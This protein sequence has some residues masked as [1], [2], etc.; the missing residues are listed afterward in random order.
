[1]KIAFV[2][3]GVMGY[4]MAG[5]LLRAGH[6]VV[7]YNRSPARAQQWCA[8]YSGSSAATPGQAALGAAYIMVCVGND[9]DVRAVVYG[10][11]GALAGMAKGAVL[12][13][14]TTCSALLAEELSQRCANDGLGF[15]DAPVSGGQ[16]GAENGT[17][18]IM[19][20]AEA[21]VFEQAQPVLRAYGRTIVHLGPAGSGQ[22]CKMA[23]QICIAGLLQ[24]LA[25]GINFA[26][27]S[28][29]DVPTVVEVLGG[30]AAQSWQLDNRGISMAEGCFDFGFALD[31]M[32]KDLAICLQEAQRLGQPLPV[33]E[34][35]DGFYAQL[36][37]QGLGGSDTSALIQRLVGNR[38]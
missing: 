24:G 8:E 36:Q 13:D 37:Q 21:A 10:E 18:S 34:L 22:R 16:A 28:G 29:L 1:M 35:V 33:T 32:R 19:V 27:A 31:W 38:S 15:M 3:L 26:Q 4:P 6:E 2:G 9:D 25:E 17:L 23:N 11:D 20:G 14:H 5:H 30:G 12:V 7:V